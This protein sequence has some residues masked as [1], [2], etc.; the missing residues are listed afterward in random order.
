MLPKR[1]DFFT[2]VPLSSLIFCRDFCGTGA[3]DFGCFGR[4][5]EFFF[6][7]QF[8]S[9]CEVKIP[10]KFRFLRNNFT[11]QRHLQ[12]TISIACSRTCSD[13]SSQSCC[14]TANGTSR[15]H[16]VPPQHSSY[17]RATKVFCLHS[18]ERSAFLQKSAYS[19]PLIFSEV[20]AFLQDL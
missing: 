19:L 13:L 20:R 11:Q 3:T 2:D 15:R 7:V 16:R 12:H 14:S 4:K 18:L 9:Q 17:L 8:Y 10:H 1:P 6:K 5:R